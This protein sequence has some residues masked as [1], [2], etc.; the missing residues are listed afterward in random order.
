MPECGTM[1]N[2]CMPVCNIAQDPAKKTFVFCEFWLLYAGMYFAILISTTKHR[3][4]SGKQRKE[5]NTMRK[6]L[7][8][9]TFFMVYLVRTG[10]KVE[11]FDTQDEAERFC[12]EWGWNYDGPEGSGFIDYKEC[13]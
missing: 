1:H 8:G 6:K 7:R 2:S 4:T 3:S 11:T 9:L 12:E 5:E 13:K 10:A